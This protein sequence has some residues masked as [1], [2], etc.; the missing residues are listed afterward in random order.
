MLVAAA[1]TENNYRPFDVDRRST[2]I[3]MANTSAFY[4]A[5]KTDNV[6]IQLYICICYSMLSLYLNG[7]IMRN[8]LGR[9]ADLFMQYWNE[10]VKVSS[11]IYA[12]VTYLRLGV[13]HEQH[14]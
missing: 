2:L 13:E 7:E 12:C 10:T 9:Q 14:L 1:L 4:M 6:N 5:L 3:R 8:E 11:I